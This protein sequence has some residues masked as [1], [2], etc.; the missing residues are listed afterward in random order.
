MICKQSSGPEIFSRLIFRSLPVPGR[1]QMLLLLNLIKNVVR[2]RSPGCT[3]TWNTKEK[4]NEK[5]IKDKTYEEG[6]QKE[7]LDQIKRLLCGP[8]RGAGGGPR[9]DRF[10]RSYVE[11]GYPQAGMDC[12]CWT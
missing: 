2:A 3:H 6:L 10:V 7:E 8:G 9:I 5:S 12:N 1:W 4:T 11:L